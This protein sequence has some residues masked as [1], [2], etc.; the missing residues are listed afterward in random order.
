MPAHQCN[1]RGRQQS[2]QARPSSSH[3]QAPQAQVPKVQPICYRGAC[4]PL[5]A[6]TLTCKRK[7]PA[8]KPVGRRADLGE[9]GL[10]KPQEAG[11]PYPACAPR[12]HRESFQDLDAKQTEAGILGGTL[13]SPQPAGALAAS[14]QRFLPGQ[15]PRYDRTSPAPRES[16][17]QAPRGGQGARH[18]REGPRPVTLLLLRGLCQKGNKKESYSRGLL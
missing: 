16:P 5:V 10:G 1:L 15:S 12:G 18:P 9:T 14:T 17:G 13:R 11:P 6:F 7:K 2:F 3:S 8:T 4:C